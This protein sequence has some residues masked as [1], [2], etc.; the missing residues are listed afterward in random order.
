MVD[1]VKERTGGALVLGQG[2][3]YPALRE[4]EREGLIVSYQVDEQLAERAGRPRKYY[5]L[6]AKG[7]RMA[8]DNECLVLGLCGAV[9]GEC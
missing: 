6:T 1:R 2:S 5:K 8:M 7:S 9:P 4:L 3:V